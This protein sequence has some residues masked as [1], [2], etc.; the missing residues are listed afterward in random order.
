MNMVEE[1]YQR[2][3]RLPSD[4][5]VK[6]LDFI[7]YLESM[8]NRQSVTTRKCPPLSE[9]LEPIQIDSWDSGIDLSRE[10]MHD[11]DGS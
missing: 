1:I 6:V 10:A 4:K 11:D 5:A 7:G 8:P 9:W 2:T 3:R